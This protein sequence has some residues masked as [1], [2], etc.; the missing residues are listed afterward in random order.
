MKNKNFHIVRHYLN[1]NVMF[2][3]QLTSKQAKQYEDYLELAYENEAG[4]MT[5]WYH[6]DIEPTQELIVDEDLPF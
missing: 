1:G 2:A 4:G 3:V 6:I 5:Y